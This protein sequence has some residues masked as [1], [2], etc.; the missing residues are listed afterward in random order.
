MQL[1]ENQGFSDILVM[2]AVPAVLEIAESLLGFNGCLNFFAGPTD[3]EFS[4]R[5]NYYDVHYSEKHIIGTTGGNVDDMK[6]ALELMEQ[7]LLK[8]EVLVTH[9]GGLDAVVETT[10]NLPNI[11][12]G[13]KLIYTG[14]SMPLTALTEL[15]S[16]MDE[17][18]FYRDLA[19]I[20]S[21][22]D[23]LWSL[24]AEEYLLK[25]GSPI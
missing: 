9:I 24:E 16:K 8:P 15:D 20:V 3:K 11:P 21:G 13:K 2:V 22:N 23:G 14:I 10:K 6:E 1:T 12:G 19:Q 7:N 25:N 4:A 18:V 5:I 17:S